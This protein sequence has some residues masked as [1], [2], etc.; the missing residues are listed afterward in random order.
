MPLAY[1]VLRAKVGE[2]A[3]AGQPVAAE[4]PARPTAETVALRT[5][6]AETQQERFPTAEA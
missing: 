2:L 4:T 5:G 6:D 3:E 1:P